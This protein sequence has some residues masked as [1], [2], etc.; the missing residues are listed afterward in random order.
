MDEN[1]AEL[2]SAMLRFSRRSRCAE[3]KEKWTAPCQVF[4]FFIKKSSVKRGC[5]LYSNKNKCMPWYTKALEELI[6]ERDSIH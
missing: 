2:L 5:Y 6:L 1:R 3:I 4:I